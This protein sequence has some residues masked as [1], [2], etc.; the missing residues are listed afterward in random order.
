MPV[1]GNEA[2][3]DT[4]RATCIQLCA[5]TRIDSTTIDMSQHHYFTTFRTKFDCIVSHRNK[6]TIAHLIGKS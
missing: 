2:V 1:S 4:A 6:I 3:L 5:N